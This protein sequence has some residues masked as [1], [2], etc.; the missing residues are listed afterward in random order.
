MIANVS[1][2][3]HD[4]DS[5]IN[6]INRDQ[7]PVFELKGEPDSIRPKVSDRSSALPGDYVA[8]SHVWVHGLGSTTE[9][10]IFSRHAKRL[11]DLVGRLSNQSGTYLLASQA[12][13]TSL[14]FNR[15]LE[16]HL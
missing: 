14:N 3:K 8:M 13:R 11:G 7:I 6:A 1:I 10:G 16:K 5:V 2:V 15:S 12:S 9:A 4:F